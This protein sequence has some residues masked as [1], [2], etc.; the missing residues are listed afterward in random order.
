MVAFFL[1]SVFDRVSIDTMSLEL[2]AANIQPRNTLKQRGH[3]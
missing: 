2:H 3:G 1:P